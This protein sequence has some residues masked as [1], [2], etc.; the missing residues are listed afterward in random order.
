MGEIR[1]LKVKKI[2]RGK[3]YP[4]SCPLPTSSLSKLITMEELNAGDKEISS[5]FY[6]TP[7]DEWSY[8]WL[9]IQP[10]NP[11]LSSKIR[12]KG[13]G[14]GSVL[15]WTERQRVITENDPFRRTAQQYKHT[16]NHILNGRGCDGIIYKHNMKNM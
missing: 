9:S 11:S 3:L 15:V 2:W 1:G 12:V 6:Q 10:L 8:T 4:S 13:G 14:H 16:H 5:P 7:P